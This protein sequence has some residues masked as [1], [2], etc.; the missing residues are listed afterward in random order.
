MLRTGVLLVSASTSPVSIEPA[1]ADDGPAILRLL[2]AA[3]LPV[4]GVLDRLDTAVVARAGGRLVGCAALEIYRDGALLRSVA[5]DAAARGQGI[6]TR[7][8]SAA[9]DLARA[10]G[11]RVVYLLTTTAEGFFPR[12]AFEPIDRQHMPA[13]VQASEEFQ[14][15]CP[16]TAI[17]M[18]KTLTD[19]FKPSTT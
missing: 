8:T 16:S 18:R 9:L 5:V 10:R 4:D 15:A 17:V 12:F 1:R 7:V 11:V 14:S 13:S 6:G 2:S 3:A 19:Y